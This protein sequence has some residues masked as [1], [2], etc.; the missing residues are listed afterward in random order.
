VLV[1]S[2]LFV[3]FNLLIFDIINIVVIFGNQMYAI[4]I[5]S[6]FFS[7]TFNC[8]TY[9]V[10]YSRIITGQTCNQ[11]CNSVTFCAVPE[12]EQHWIMQYPNSVG[13]KRQPWMVLTGLIL[14]ASSDNCLQL[15]SCAL[16]IPFTVTFHQLSLL[17]FVAIAHAV[18]KWLNWL[19]FRCRRGNV[20][21]RQN[22]HIIT[23]TRLCDCEW[24]RR[25]G[26]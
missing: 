25:Q 18:P 2:F 9:Y 14:H 13:L 22:A 6:D 19:F 11:P 1:L 3:I 15:I 23:L 16:D 10:L 5:K 12:T 26:V 24:S 21:G 20:W 4:S 17:I 8:S 7:V